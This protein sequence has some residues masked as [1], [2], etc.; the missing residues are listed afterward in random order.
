MYHQQKILHQGDLEKIKSI[1]SGLNLL[2][3]KQKQ[4]VDE[5]STG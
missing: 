2:F 5:N 4:K 3:T 1:L